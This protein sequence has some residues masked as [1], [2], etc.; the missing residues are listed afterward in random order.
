[1][2]T[3]VRGILALAAFLLVAG[4]LPAQNQAQPPLR[5]I[6]GVWK[7]SSGAGYASKHM[8][9]TAWDQ[10]AA[11]AVLVKDKAG[12]VQVTQRYNEAGGSAAALARASWT[13]SRPS[14]RTMW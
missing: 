13:R 3:Y 4:E 14:A 5:M 9:K 8:S 7:D 12:H 1:M 10:V 6:F 2:G 11:G